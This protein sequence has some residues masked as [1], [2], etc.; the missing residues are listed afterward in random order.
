MRPLC[1][2]YPGGLP[3]AAIPQQRMDQATRSC[4]IVPPQGHAAAA[5]CRWLALA[6]ASGLPRHHGP[7]NPTM[8]HNMCCLL[9]AL[10]GRCVQSGRLHHLFKAWPGLRAM[11]SHAAQLAHL[12]SGT[13]F[14]T[15]H[16]CQIC[17]KPV[18]I[19]ALHASTNAVWV[20]VFLQQ[21]E[22]LKALT[23]SSSPASVRSMHR[24]W[25]LKADG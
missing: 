9:P 19:Q 8:P 16:H 14:E 10:P 22:F 7:W 1:S 21:I 11:A 6:A 5:G 18:L 23:C 4:G 20:P 3:G 12:C 15:V 17:A 25:S 24:P 13:R 2:R